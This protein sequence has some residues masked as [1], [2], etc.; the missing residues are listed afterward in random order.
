M[1]TY[2]CQHLCKG[3]RRFR[4]PF[5]LDETDSWQRPRDFNANPYSCYQD[6]VLGKKWPNNHCA[7]QCQP[8]QLLPGLLF[9]RYDSTTVH[10]NAS[11]Y[12]CYQ[13]SVLGKKWLNPCALQM[14]APIQLLPGLCSWYDM[15]QPL[16]TSNASTYTSASK[17]LYSVRYESTPVHFHVSIYRCY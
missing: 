10:S 3:E 5:P 1:S 13:Y 15:T 11:S 9:V 4:P 16:C 2:F 14:P 12:S 7:L 6:T 17:I 8:L